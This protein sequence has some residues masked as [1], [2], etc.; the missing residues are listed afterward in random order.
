MSQDWG[1]AT[2]MCPFSCKTVSYTD[3]PAKLS[4]YPD[5][6]SC[7][8]TLNKPNFY[9]W[10]LAKLS[11]YNNFNSCHRTQQAKLLCLVSCKAVSVYQ[12]SFMSQ[13]SEQAK[14]LC[15]FSCEAVSVSWCYLVCC[16]DMF[17]KKGIIIVHRRQSHFGE[18]SKMISLWWSLENKKRL[19]CNWLL[20]AD[21][22][23]GS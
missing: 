17:D 11:V 20:Y 21:R 4:V 13:D 23:N 15:L 9:A 3:S 19:N 14:L 7:H 22:H 8:R 6:H 10:S 12:L 2:L 18:S 16:W 5:F 1:K